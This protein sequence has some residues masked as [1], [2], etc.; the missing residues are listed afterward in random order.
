M[1]PRFSKAS[2]YASSSIVKNCLSIR[3]YGRALSLTRSG[4][5]S[6]RLYFVCIFG[7][8]SKLLLVDKHSSSLNSDTKF[9]WLESTMSIM[10][11]YI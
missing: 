4:L 11:L 7:M 8:D 3:H 9:V 10:W 6:E 2:H 1:E 5:L